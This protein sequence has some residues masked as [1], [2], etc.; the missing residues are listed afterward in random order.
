M[1]EGLKSNTHILISLNLFFTLGLF[2]FSDEGSSSSKSMIV[3]S[4]DGRSPSEKELKKIICHNAFYS[5]KNESINSHFFHIDLINQIDETVIEIAK[6]TSQFFVKM[7]G[8]DICRVVA[9]KED[10]FSAFE[11]IISESGPI[12][13]QVSSIRVKKPKFSEV[14]EYL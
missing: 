8:R 13:Y 14:K 2:L 3:L 9:K 7:D 5:L 12:I 10:G 4:Q 1:I 11:A 6:E